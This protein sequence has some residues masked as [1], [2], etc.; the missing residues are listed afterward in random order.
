MTI[1][2]I[3]G[4]EAEVTSLSICNYALQLLGEGKITQGELDGESTKPARLCAQFFPYARNHVLEKHNWGFAEK[5]RLLDY[6]DDFGIY[7][8]DGTDNDVETITDIT[9]AAPPVVTVTS[10]PY[11][12]GNLVKIYDVSGM[13]EVNEKIYEVTKVDANTFSLTDIDG[14]KYTTYT[15][16]GKCIRMEVASKYAQ[17]YTYDVPSDCLVPIRIDDGGPGP[18]PEFITISADVNARILTTVEDAVL[19]YTA[20]ITDADIWPTKFINCVAAFLAI[21]L[22]VPLKKK[23]ADVKQAS[24]LFAEY[25]GI[26]TVADSR[27]SITTPNTDDSWLSDAGL[28]Q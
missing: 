12:T 6:T 4:A 9:S 7:P 16:G 1:V 25:F 28:M 26:G 13:T 15:S 24:S 17:G 21:L 19:I 5:H 27:G 14:T 2:L 3:G 10:H 11:V 22:A 20:K 8:D 23:A 18:G